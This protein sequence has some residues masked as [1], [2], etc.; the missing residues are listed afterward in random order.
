MDRASA[1]AH[2]TVTDTTLAL[3]IVPTDSRYLWCS[4]SRPHDI[5][6][7]QA[8]LLLLM[9]PSGPLA[10]VPPYTAH[11]GESDL[12]LCSLLP[13]GPFNLRELDRL[14]V[15]RVRATVFRLRI[16]FFRLGGMSTRSGGTT[17]VSSKNMFCGSKSDSSVVRGVLNRRRA[18][19]EK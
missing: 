1:R 19:A 2:R 3:C 14:K 6:R 7:L 11:V 9:P 10:S 4:V 5:G 18:S 13:S 16:V 8:A 15:L 12:V 17:T